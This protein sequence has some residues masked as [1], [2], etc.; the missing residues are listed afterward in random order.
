M[1]VE[2]QKQRQWK[3]IPKK[4]PPICLEEGNPVKAKSS[5]E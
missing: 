4:W 5:T 1:S 3:T 2:L